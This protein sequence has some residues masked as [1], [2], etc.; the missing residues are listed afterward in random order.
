MKLRNALAPCALAALVGGCAVHPP[1][2][3]IAVLRAPQPVLV[4]PA[5]VV[6]GP[7]PVFVAPAYGKPHPG[8]GW[9]HG[10]HKHHH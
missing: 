2:P 9:A 8:R 10:K 1:G 4:A 5:P 3:P 7:A 6:V